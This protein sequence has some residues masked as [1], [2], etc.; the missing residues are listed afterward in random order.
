MQYS[1]SIEGGKK[2]ANLS[3]GNL[4]PYAEKVVGLDAKLCD[5]YRYI[6]K[7]IH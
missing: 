2:E 1:Y 5:L 7:Q 3:K 6:N 4:C